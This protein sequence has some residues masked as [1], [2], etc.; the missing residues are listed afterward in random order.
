MDQWE[1]DLS[2]M[3]GIANAFLV[4]VFV[5]TVVSVGFYTWPFWKLV[6]GLMWVS[7]FG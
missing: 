3:R 7:Y 2:A 6:F 5:L 1:D 4:T